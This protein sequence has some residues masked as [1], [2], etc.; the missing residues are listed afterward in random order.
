MK[1][2]KFKKLPANFGK[3]KLYK[4]ESLMP[5]D[6]YEYAKAFRSIYTRTAPMLKPID[7]SESATEE[8][9]GQFYGKVQ[10]LAVQISISNELLLKSV[11]LGSSG[12]YTMTHSLE[13]L[14]Y[15]LDERHQSIIT[16]HMVHNGLNDGKW[17]TVLG[18]SADTFVNARYGFQGKDYVVDFRTLQLFNEALDNIINNYTPDWTVLTRSQQKDKEVLKGELDLIFDE[19]YQKERK[20][21]LAL[22]DKVINNLR[23]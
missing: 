18:Y 16:E 12:R 17:A 13:E 9:I 19:T 8:E 23:K 3:V 15:E 6:I 5:S 1:Y 20:N 4:T 21:T 22:I 10:S 7:S 11:L 2:Y 14:F